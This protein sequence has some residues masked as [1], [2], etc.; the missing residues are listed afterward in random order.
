IDNTHR[1]RAALHS[2]PI[3]TPRHTTP[4]RITENQKQRKGKQ[5]QRAR[6]G[7]RPRDCR[8]RDGRRR[9]AQEEDGGQEKRWAARPVASGAT[10]GRREG[11]GARRVRGLVLHLLRVPAGRRALL[12]G[13]RGGA[14]GGRRRGGPRGSLVA[15]S[16]GSFYPS[17]IM[18]PVNFHDCWSYG[19]PCREKT[20]KM[21]FSV[22]HS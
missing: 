7:R 21:W 1:R 17:K 19:V 13:A 22:S 6:D 18:T 8:P 14:G 15:F 10:R 4:I 16:A 12:R 9:A 20:L 2:H 3:P 5:G 11:R